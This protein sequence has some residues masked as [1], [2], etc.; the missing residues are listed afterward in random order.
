MNSH[1][2]DSARALNESQQ[3][4]LRVSCQYVDK[5]LS[6]IE[7]I[8]SSSASKSAFPRYISE[9]SPANR[10]TIEDYIARIRAQLLRILEG[11]HIAPEKPAIPDTRAISVT[12]GA[13][14]IAVDEL[15]PKNMRGYGEVP[16]SVALDLNGIVGEVQ[17]LVS[18]LNQGEGEDLQSRLLRLEQTSD[19]FALLRKIE[20]IVAQRGLV[21]FRTAIAAILDRMEDK[22]FEIAVFGR[23]SSG[24]SSLLNGIL[25]ADV[26]PVGVTPITAVP[27]RIKYA[28]V[29]S[30]SVSFA[31][32]SP[33]KLE[34]SRLSEFASEQQNPAN[35]KHVT[36]IV[37]K[38]PAERLRDGVTFVDTP[39]LGSLATRGAAETLAYL[40]R[41]DLGVVLVDS[42]TTLAPDDLLTIQTLEEAAIPVHL[43]LS[44]ADL[45]RPSDREQILS[46]VREHVTAEC[47]LDLPV[48]PVSALA[49]HRAMLDQWFKD[50]ILP[51]CERAQELRAASLKRKIGALRESVVAALRVNL[52][53][54]Q[55]EHTPDEGR[56]RDV[57]A[58][59]RQ[60]TGKV[61][62]LRAVVDRELDM[63]PLASAQIFDEVAA[64]LS[65]EQLSETSAETTTVRTMIVNA[66]HERAR[67]FHE[68]IQNIARFC[69][70]EL[71][72]AARE[73][74]LSSMPAD[75]EFDTLVR[76]EPIFEFPKKI[77]AARSTLGSLFGARFAVKRI[78]QQL[79]SKIGAELDQGLATYA[80]LLRS[81][82]ML[83]LNQL[84]HAFDGY[85]DSYR[86]HIE[87]TLAEE[88]PG[89]NEVEGIA[90]DLASL[91]AR[92]EAV[93]V[94]RRDSQDERA[95]PF[96]DAAMVRS[97]KRA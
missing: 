85:A 96:G 33:Q 65:V 40:P 25:G 70:A 8:L 72:A 32:R 60:A 38:L 12:L 15:K 53:R 59:L 89:A 55:G 48:H 83:V 50:E 19:E 30:V 90:R 31:E 2:G 86:A 58:K 76:G 84:K 24:K 80:G 18:R 57:E 21:E 43:L 54:R 69:A 49:S 63:L 56:L 37:L 95:K 68:R 29:P 74:E 5:L 6:E 77:E 73:L 3:R 52:Q 91:G 39:G 75:G 10:G 94:G 45:L 93:S 36:R 46:Y 35:R 9:I 7:S 82:V 92:S 67:S 51:L 23:V 16:E 64:R 44:K 62:E 42:G 87:R 79:A 22:S 13:I 41:C 34:V 27:T 26:L 71:I 14:D 66:V 17:G 61:E 20:R 81:W 97:G 88:T 47:H 11:Q 1:M 78:T 4:H 28:A